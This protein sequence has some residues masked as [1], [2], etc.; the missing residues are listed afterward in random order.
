MEEDENCASCAQ[1]P[2]SVGHLV[3]SASTQVSEISWGSCLCHC[4]KIE[5]SEKEEKVN[6]TNTSWSRVVSAAKI[7]QDGTWA[8]LCQEQCS[9][10]ESTPRGWYHRRCYAAY[11]HKKTLSR[12]EGEESGGLVS[13]VD[14]EE[15]G[16]AD[17][18]EDEPPKKRVMTRSKV[19]TIDITLCIICQQKTKKRTG[20]LN[21]L[22]S[23]QNSVLAKA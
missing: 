9:T 22:P 5:G 15:V 2:G 3:A 7:R 8:F 14:A 1:S 11:T 4:V 16:D 19:T 13:N 17:A 12:F 23:V 20:K 6:F 10:D 21:R 18:C